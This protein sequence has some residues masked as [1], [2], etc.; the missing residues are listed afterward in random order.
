MAS[1]KQFGT[2]WVERLFSVFVGRLKVQFG[3]D[4]IREVFSRYRRVIDGHIP[5]RQDRDREFAF[6]RFL[7]VEGMKRVL[8]RRE[9]LVV[10]AAECLWRRR[11]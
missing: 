11:R 6:V 9:E 2:K 1:K 7:H 8:K 10:R 5:L 3:A 4:G